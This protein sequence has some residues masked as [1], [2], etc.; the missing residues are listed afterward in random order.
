MM[1]RILGMDEKSASVKTDGCAYDGRFFFVFLGLGNSIRFQCFESSVSKNIS[2]NGMRRR[3]NFDNIRTNELLILRHEKA[4]GYYF[5]QYNKL[6]VE[7]VQSYLA[8]QHKK[9]TE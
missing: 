1:A 2:L 6:D 7:L 3:L 8:I 5:V 4:Y 9:I